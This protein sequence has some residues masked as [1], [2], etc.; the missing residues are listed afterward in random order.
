MQYYSFNDDTRTEWPFFTK[1]ILFCSSQKTLES[2]EKCIA[3]CC[4]KLCSRGHIVAA[5]AILYTISF[6]LQKVKAVFD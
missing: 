4:Q 3:Q 1:F 2:V 5:N 6:L